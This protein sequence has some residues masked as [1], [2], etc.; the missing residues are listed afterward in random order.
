MSRSRTIRRAA[1]ASAAVAS[2]LLAVVPASEAAARSQQ[3]PRGA[4]GKTHAQQQRSAAVQQLP[5]APGVPL[6]P[7]GAAFYTPPKRLP[8]G[9]PGTVVWAR[10]IQAPKGAWA[11]KVLYK[12]TLQNGRAV[13]VSGLVISPRGRAPKHGRPV[14]AWAHGTLGGANDCAPSI[15]ADPAHNLVDYYT[16]GA[17]DFIDTGVPALTTLLKAGYTV[18]ATDYQGLGTPGVH[19]YTVGDTEARNVF[20]S[21]KAAQRLPAAAAGNR[22]ALLGWSQGGGAAIFAGQTTNA[23]Y[24]KPLKVVGIAALAPAANTAGDIEGRVAPGPTDALYPANTA[25]QELNL[26]RGLAAA[27]PELNV[28][29]VVSSAGMAPFKALNVECT[30]HL[31][32][33]IQ[34]LGVDPETLFKRP[35]PSAWRA[36]FQQNTAGLQATVAPIL[37][38]QGTTDTVVNP[39]G[40]TQY[41]QRACA[42]GQPVEYSIYPGDNHQT[43]PF[44]A[45]REYV[46]WIKD[47]FAGKRAPSNCGLQVP[48]YPATPPTTP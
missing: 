44:A 45:Q 20:D 17:R 25:V 40:T 32:D 22:V 34:E 21:V 5:G 6:G 33:V 35:A 38:M 19:Q 12:S 26:Y 13:A 36:R 47:R 11:W 2:A 1:L 46:A 39:N 9:R 16:Y 43:I 3:P 27:Y 48:N 30:V 8:K 4:S 41:I 24:G 42:F 37:T 14:V 15:P 23:T 31:A 7:A 29:D 10:P 18:T 28:S